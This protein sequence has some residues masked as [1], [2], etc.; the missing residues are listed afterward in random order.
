MV[1]SFEP[2]FAAIFTHMRPDLFKYIALFESCS[3]SFEA[4]FAYR[5]FFLIKWNQISIQI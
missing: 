5:C 3:K 4:V 1:V 2:G